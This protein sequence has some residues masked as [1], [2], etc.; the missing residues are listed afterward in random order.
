MSKKK[1]TQKRL[2]ELLHYDPETG[3]F[4]WKGF[5]ISQGRISLK[6]GRIAGYQDTYGYRQIHIRGTLYQE[7]RLVWLYVYGYTPENSIDHINRNPS[8]NRVKNL[9]E[10]SSQCNLRNQGNPK[11]NTSGVTGVSWQTAGGRWIAQITVMNKNKNIGRYTDFSEAVCARLAG[12]QCLDW[13]NCDSSSPAFQYVQNML[14]R[15]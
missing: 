1:L 14:G 7:H 12:E 9:R 11:N 8:D 3:V 5:S 13:A 6:S 4:T 15:L 10:V 2:K